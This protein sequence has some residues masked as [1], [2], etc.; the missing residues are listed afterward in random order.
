M[1]DLIVAYNTKTSVLA[2]PA[3]NPDSNAFPG[4][5]G[6]RATR[7]RPLQGPVSQRRRVWRRGA[8][9]GR[10]FGHVRGM[11]L[12]R[13]PLGENFIVL[14]GIV[15]KVLA[16]T[17]DKY[18]RGRY[19]HDQPRFNQRRNCGG[20]RDPTDVAA[21]ETGATCPGYGTYQSTGCGGFTRRRHRPRRRQPLIRTAA[22][23][24]SRTAAA[25]HCRSR[26]SSRAS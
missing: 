6:V 1:T 18:Q 25:V 23:L 16:E 13:V 5:P 22:S 15:P 7:R 14:P 24:K 19:F 20:K 21:S 4:R 17:A 11:P 8:S 10:T 26:R 9:A 3:A 2:G 12:R